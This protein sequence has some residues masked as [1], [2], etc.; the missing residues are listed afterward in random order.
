MLHLV[1]SDDVR[2][3]ATLDYV[4]AF[5]DADH[6]IRDLSL[7]GPAKL[8][9][10]NRRIEKLFQHT[11]EPLL[12]SW[13]TARLLKPQTGPGDI[14][15]ISDH[16]GLGGIFALEQ[17]ALDPDLRRWVWTVAADSAYLELRLVAKTHE[18]F[19]MP[20]DSEVDW[21]IAQYRWSDRVIATSQFAVDELARLGVD[22]ELVGT[23]APSPGSTTEVTAESIWMPGTVS[24]RN[25]SGEVLRAITSVPGAVVTLSEHDSEDGI[26]SGTA[27]EAMRHSRAVLGE[28]VSRG[29]A[30]ARPS[31]IVLGDPFAP[32]DSST[33]AFHAAGVP[34]LVPSGGVA[35]EVWPDAPTWSNADELC[36]LFPGGRPARTGHPEPAP[37]VAVA[38]TAAAPDGDRARSV[39]VGIPIFRDVRF[40]DEC[41]GSVLGQTQPPL[42]VVL[43]D[44]G[45]GS[46]EVDQALA[47]LANHDPRIVTIVTEHRGVCA[48]RNTMLETMEGDAFVFVDSDDVLHPE[49]IERCARVM[50]GHADVWAVATW[51]EFF[52]EYEGIEAKPPFDDRVGLRE[53]PIISTTALV[54]MKVREKGIRFADDLAFLFCEDW[55][56]WSQIVAAGGRFGLVPEPLA[57]HRVHPSSGGYLRTELTHAIGRTRATEPLRTADSQ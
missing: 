16:Q 54:D 39:S 50:G 8:D 44:D 18:G 40:L 15:L 35:H 29:P 57:K 53:N 22:A 17:A 56:L 9:R 36:R 12:A 3:M 31:V 5:L 33:T 13:R 48:A 30:P 47:R 55:N 19:P 10:E 2:A 41:V 20:L 28:R 49:F 37:A 46:E 34:V 27:W 42:E 21:E 7:T 1:A 26:W 25:Q 32:P 43:V 45:S 38:S 14:V 23:P 6:E 24:R 51:T 52:G 11:P 4:R